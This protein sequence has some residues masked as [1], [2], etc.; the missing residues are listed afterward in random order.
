MGI[1]FLSPALL[2]GLLAAAIPVIVH[3][4]HRRRAK[5]LPIATL[6]FLRLVPA[7]TIRR[8]RIE[9]YLLMLARIALFV[10]LALGAARPVLT[11]AEAGG[12]A[13][14]AVLVI[15]DSYSME[16]REK[17][18]TRFQAAVEAGL[19]ALRTFRAGDRAAIL[20]ASDPSG[21]APT[22]DLA[23]LRRRLGAARPSLAAKDLL[24]AGA[25]AFEILREAREPNRELILVTDFQATAVGPLAEQLPSDPR[26]ERIR[27]LA[28]DVRAE[29]PA[30]L[31]VVAAR[32]GEVALAGEPQRVTAEV[33]NLSTTGVATRVSLTLGEERIED[34]QVTVAAG[35][36][37]TVVFAAKVETPG[38]EGGRITILPD[39]LP[40]DDVRWFI[41]PVLSRVP[42]LLVNGDPS[43]VSWQDE[44]FF[45]RA[46]LSPEEMGAEKVRSPFNLKVIT[47]D[48]LDGE[49]LHPF[50]AVILANVAS[51]TPRAAA[52]LRAFV[53]AGG[54]ALF[55]AGSRVRA[56]E[57][58]RDLSTDP[59]EGLLPAV[60]SPPTQL[61]TDPEEV[62]LLGEAD[63]THPLLEGLPA[64]AIAD[65]PRIHARR[66]LGAD[67]ASAA[68]RVLARLMTGAP[69]LLEKT[70]GRGRVLLFTTSADADWGNLPLR[71]L[72]L[73]LLHRSLLLLAGGEPGA[74]DRLVGEAAK[75]PAPTVATAPP[76]VTDP[77]G[78]VSRP[79]GE[80]AELSTAP[81]MIPGVFRVKGSG[82]GDYLF[83][84][85]VDPR[86]GDLTPADPGL[87]EERFGPDRFRAVRGLAE[88]EAR[89]T[90]AREGRPLWGFFLAAA[91]LLLL[92]EGFFANRI[93]T[94]RADRKAAGA[95]SGEAP[96]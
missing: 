77:R 68:G 44:A 43:P 31:T 49:D 26:D 17:G 42:V 61:G 41:V 46:A 82:V 70:V 48:A 80:G 93:S 4:M 24:A 37:A 79:T 75:V 25:K 87:F 18:V 3:L 78:E 14:V 35:E 5:I 73:P 67:A 53:R 85:N 63:R 92:F 36:T 86:E 20:F 52:T 29:A 11:G 39:D 89:L 90:R 40:A 9:E 13:T 38:A 57:Y 69:F 64:E 59:A 81:L 76:E 71:P 83:A 32:A 27:V 15:D 22:T 21:E 6:R 55:F 94:A 84:V 30:N 23:A 58:N 74:F 96:R 19:R 2:A 95:A 50:R 62:I 10:A 1:S 47:T 45:L 7:R 66:A 56:D 54:G 51:F 65:L 72:F 12:G 16:V 34:R 8:R 60:L 88:F 33:R 28:V 91:L